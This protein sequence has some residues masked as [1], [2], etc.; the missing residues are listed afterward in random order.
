M[1][2]VKQHDALCC[3]MIG[4]SQIN[5]V[6]LAG[7]EFLLCVSLPSRTCTTGTHA[8]SPTIVS[9]IAH[10]VQGG[11]ACIMYIIL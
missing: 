10:R 9:V 7:P 4:S 11:Q 2:L 8:P 6:A 3:Y 5:N 1:N